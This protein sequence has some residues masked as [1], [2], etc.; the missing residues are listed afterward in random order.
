M[1]YQV[2]IINTDHQIFVRIIVYQ[3]KFLL[4]DVIKGATED[5]RC[6]LLGCRYEAILA[7]CLDHYEVMHRADLVGK[8]GVIV[9]QI[10]QDSLFRMC[11][12]KP[13]GKGTAADLLRLVG[14]HVGK[15]VHQGVHGHCGVVGAANLLIVETEMCQHNPLTL[16]YMFIAKNA[17]FVIVVF[18]NNCFK[19]NKICH[20]IMKC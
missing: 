6:K 17:M 11:A 13:F 1:Y 3:I 9:P 15:F 4:S 7:E 5:G 18:C 12:C 20:L 8:A 16:Q 10:C 14:E 19:Q 2:V